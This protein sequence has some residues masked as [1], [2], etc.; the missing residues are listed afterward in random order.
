MVMVVISAMA[1]GIAIGMVGQR[2]IWKSFRWL[3]ARVGDGGDGCS[4]VLGQYVAKWGL[5]MAETW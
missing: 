5:G 2:M 4:K 3:M 1:M